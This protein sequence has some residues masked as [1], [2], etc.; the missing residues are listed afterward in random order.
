MTDRAIVVILEP[1]DEDREPGAIVQDEYTE[2]IYPF[3]FFDWRDAVHYVQWCRINKLF[4]GDDFYTWT[5]Q[6]GYQDFG[7]FCGEYDEF[8]G[9]DEVD[10]ILTNTDMTIIS[11]TQLSTLSAY[12]LLDY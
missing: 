6:Y 12:D 4:I 7:K 9:R 11:E 10:Y 3:E 5:H 8:M 1:V 2:E